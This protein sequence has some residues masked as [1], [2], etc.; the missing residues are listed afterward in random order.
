MST[1][2]AAEGMRRS[3]ASAPVP[4]PVQALDQATGYLVAAAVIRGL[5]ARLTSGA[6]LEAHASLARTALTLQQFRPESLPQPL[7]PEVPAD[8]NGAIERT[9]WG[10]ARRARRDSC[11]RR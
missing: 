11:R 4:L 2:I 5:T 10:V 8:L 1:G 9:A 3:G 7:A 6:G